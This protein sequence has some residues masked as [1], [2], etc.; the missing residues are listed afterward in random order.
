[1]PEIDDRILAGLKD[2]LTK[3][4]SQNSFV[5]DIRQFRQAY[6]I[7]K[8]LA[9]LTDALINDLLTHPELAK[10]GGPWLLSEVEKPLYQ[11]SRQSNQRFDF[12]T[13][14]LTK[15]RSLQDIVLL[16]SIEEEEK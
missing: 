14:S 5:V 12:P 1:M 10:M 3:M 7:P 6:R 2:L 9:H 8:A 11:F 15:F 13:Q 4:S 16:A